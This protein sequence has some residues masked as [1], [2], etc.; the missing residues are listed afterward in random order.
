M[1]F[2]L[3]ILYDR[4]VITAIIEVLKYML[5]YLFYITLGALV[6]LIKGLVIIDHCTAYIRSDTTVKQEP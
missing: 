1:H 4:N 3:T 6:S 2:C 5:N